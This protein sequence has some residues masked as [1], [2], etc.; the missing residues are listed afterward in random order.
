M[1]VNGVN[2]I[3][4]LSRNIFQPLRVVPHHIYKFRCLIR[5]MEPCKP[6]MSRK[7]KLDRVL[8]ACDRSNSSN[9]SDFEVLPHSRKGGEWCP[10]TD[11]SG[12]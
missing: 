10:G 8:G 1:P 3:I 5:T 9:T 6:Y 11:E 7:S 4:C 2:R 12:R